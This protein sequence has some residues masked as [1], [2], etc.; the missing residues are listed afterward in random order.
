M[1]RTATGSALSFGTTRWP[2]PTSLSRR[3]CRSL[4]WSANSPIGGETREVS[5]R[6]E[7]RVAHVAPLLTRVALLGCCTCR[8]DNKAHPLY[9]WQS[10]CKPQLL[11]PASKSVTALHAGASESAACAAAR[12]LALAARHP[13][14]RSPWCSCEP[15]FVSYRKWN[16]ESM[17]LAISFHLQGG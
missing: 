1:L 7:G 14:S 2:G 17:V 8:P 5:E 16:L 15:S 13:S 3:A 11:R 4:A 12:C 9:I 6:W 10:P